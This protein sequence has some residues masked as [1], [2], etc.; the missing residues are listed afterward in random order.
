MD[1]FISYANADKKFAHATK[2]A[3][4]D[5]GFTG[6]L[7]HEDLAVS[8]EWRDEILVK[9]QSVTV[10]VALLSKHFKASEWCA[11]EVGFILSR[12][13]VLIMPLSLDG[14]VSFGFMSKIQSKVVHDEIEI[15]DILRDALF[16]KRPRILIPRWIK[17][18]AAAT[19]WRRAEAL[20]KPLVS[21]Y[22]AFTDEEANAFLEAALGNPQ[23][24]DAG[25]CRSEYLPE[26]ARLHWARLS[27][28]LRERFLETL[29]LS[30]DDIGPA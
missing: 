29:E 28:T 12:P 6:F 11:Q 27:K 18:V 8:E 5:L 9:L 13:E 3:L 15:P 17:R 4:R 7:A 21:H 25:A 30:E 26:F 16:R 2:S 20:V 10:L 23:V 19:A 24:W 14:T 22:A 1:A